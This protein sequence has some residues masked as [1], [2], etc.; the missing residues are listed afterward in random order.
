[1]AFQIVN[2]VHVQFIFFFFLLQIGSRGSLFKYLFSQNKLIPFPFYITYYLKR[3][4]CHV[5]LFLKEPIML[6]NFARI[7]L[8]KPLHKSIMSLPY[9]KNKNKTQKNPLFLVNIRHILRVP[10]FKS[11]IEGVFSS[12]NISPSCSSELATHSISSCRWLAAAAL[13]SAGISPYRT[14]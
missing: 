9:K 13:N 1:M 8:I 4:I 7:S 12:R 2:S 5:T 11:E 14:I 6:N 3:V 10:A